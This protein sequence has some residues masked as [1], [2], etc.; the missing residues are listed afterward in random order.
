[1][2]YVHGPTMSQ[3]MAERPIQLD[4]ILDIAIQI[5]QGLEEAHHQNVI[6]RDI[7]PDNIMRSETGRIKIMD[8][9]L[10]KI[11]GQSRLTRDG[12]SMG[13]IDYMSPEQINH[14]SE[15]EQRS[16]LFS[17]GTLLYEMITG[18]LPFKGEH[19]WAV[20]Y[21][22]LNNE[23]E[24][25]DL[26]INKI[27]KAL[28]TL[29]FKCLKKIPQQRYQSSRE[30]ITD[31]IAIQQQYLRSK[32]L[33]VRR[34]PNWWWI[35][36]LAGLVLL[37]I[38][39]FI[40][41]PF[42]GPSPQKL[43][44]QA[45]QLLKQRQFSSA[46]SK[47]RQAIRSDSAFS[48]AWSNLAMAF[49]FENQIDSTIFFASQALK[50]DSTNVI[51][52]SILGRAYELQEMP[53]QA[54]RIYR[55]AIARDSLFIEAYINAGSL[56]IVQD[57]IEPALTLLTSAMQKSQNSIEKAYISKHLG[58]IYLQKHQYLE[59]IAYFRQALKLDPKI[60][61]VALLL[62]EAITAQNSAGD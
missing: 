52:Y 17:Y 49:Y 39:A 38:A 40:W 11:R 30:I 20:L 53:D 29:V 24:A 3:L 55:Q 51:A 54:I 13:T 32:P 2:E 27:P 7:K 42:A 26:N 21:A 8:F 43:N 58:I 9:G 61:D 44:N 37:G 1:M 10:A 60:E 25:I 46:K 31:L 5:A 6:H 15:V 41:G 12:F 23:P 47:L 50:T 14:E 35:S 33:P 36:A 22:I 59:A 4:Q 18:E 16:D 56:L 45:V 34:R 48:S 57:Q 62:K 28:E 19:D